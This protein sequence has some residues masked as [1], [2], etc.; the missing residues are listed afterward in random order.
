MRETEEF[1][2]KFKK[3]FAKFFENKTSNEGTLQKD[4]ELYVNKFVQ[5]QQRWSIVNKITSQ[6]TSSIVPSSIYR[7]VISEL[8]E[9]LNIT[10]CGI[11]TYDENLQKF[12]LNYVD[13]K[14]ENIDYLSLHIQKCNDILEHKDLDS[15]GLVAI[16]S[17][18]PVENLYSVPLI[19]K[20]K[21]LGTIYVY[22]A[23]SPIDKES[24]DILTLVADNIAFAIMNANL[25]AILE[26]KDKD[27]LE[28]IASMSHEFKN[29]LNTII[30]FT[31]LLRE[32]AIDD[33]ETALRYL[34]NIIISSHHMSNLVADIIEMSRMESG[35]IEL[36]CEEFSPKVVIIEVLST[37]ESE[38]MNKN[39]NLK[40]SLNDCPVFA[41]TKRFRQIIY[42][43]VSN[44][45]KFVKDGG[46]IE[47][48]TFC[49]N[50]WFNF[51]ITDNGEGIG[52]EHKGK[53]FKFFAQGSDNFAK[54]RE[55][56]G[57]GLAVC[58]NVIDAHQGEINFDS[59]KGVGS[60][61]WFKL[62]VSKHLLLEGK[63]SC[64]HSVN[65]PGSSSRNGR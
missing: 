36:V 27:K 42:N 13:S 4:L 18:N 56:Y 63:Q 26:Q 2:K 29:P 1:L 19:N 49:K 11:C 53:L 46:V 61:F 8:K 31:N 51:E 15:K 22:N 14:S 39:I 48:S 17:E 25:Y 64:K 60:K 58:K 44:A 32:G 6:I 62:P 35:K 3:V 7:T 28:F 9:M 10:S 30:G 24:M 16:F 65:S 59:Q 45:L 54:R 52:E 40:T 50:G 21:F 23:D 41:D 38:I 47:I 20:D 33:H 5:N 55:G 43:L 12:V 57:V 37:H 34:N